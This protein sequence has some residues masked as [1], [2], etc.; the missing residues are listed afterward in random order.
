MSETQ[1][2][3]TPGL[4]ADEQQEVSSNQPPRAAVLHET[5]RLQGDQELERTLAALWWSALAAGLSMGLSLMAMGLLLASAGRRE[6]AGHRQYR[7]Q[8][9]LP[10]RHHRAAAIVH[11]EHPDRCPASDDD[12]NAG[13]LRSLAAPVGR[14]P[15]RQPGRYS[16]GGLGDARTADL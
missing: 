2:E 1:S 6:R 5:I 14:G 3:K 16:I 11:R 8:R 7:L 4:S 13:Q 10:G 9:R 12:A 15:G